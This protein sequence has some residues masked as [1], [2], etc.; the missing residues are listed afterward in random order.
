MPQN[1]SKYEKFKEIHT[2]KHYNQTVE[3]QRQREI[4]E[5]RKREVTHHLQRILSKINSWFLIINNRD[6]RKWYKIFK[7]LKGKGYQPKNLYPA[8]LFY[9]NKGEIKVFPNKQ[10]LN[11]ERTTHTIM[12]EHTFHLV[13]LLLLP[14]WITCFD[15]VSCHV[16]EAYW[17]GTKGSLWLAVR[18]TEVLCPVAH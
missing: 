9:K 11:C 8:K 13:G 14:F 3:K 18:E 1:F 12:K 6:K 17:Q 10:K 15:E 2:Y 16:W 7:A 4:V 5:K